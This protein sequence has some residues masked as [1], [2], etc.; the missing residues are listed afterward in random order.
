MDALWKGSP[1]FVAG[2]RGYRPEA[3]VIHV[4]AGTLVGTDAWFKNPESKVSAHYGIG[5]EG[6]VHQYVKESDTAWH[7]GRRTSDASWS[8]LK[9]RVNPNLYTIGIE[10][11][12]QVDDPWPDAMYES[13]AKL[14]QQACLRWDIPIDR[15]HVIGHREI[16]SR[17]S[18]PGSRA[19]L[20]RLVKMAGGQ[21]DDPES[22]N[23]VRTRGKV[24]VRR[25]LNVRQGLPTTR[26]PKAGRLKEGEELTY[27]GWTSN[28]QSV[29]GNAH[30]YRNADGDYLWAGA[31]SEPVPGLA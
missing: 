2:R 13:S 31:T 22:F 8:L 17:K 28:G 23:L 10:H 29:D 20:T 5:R 11:E 19:S 6:Q 24:T 14:I 21:A 15:K 30:W 12:G 26:A 27:V 7:A 3:V 9:P 18:C 1:N 16:F 4:M 25:T